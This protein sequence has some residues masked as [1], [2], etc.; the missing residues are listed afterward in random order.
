MLPLLRVKKTCVVVREV[1]DFNY[2]TF[3]AC[4]FVYVWVIRLERNLTVSNF[5]VL[6]FV[7]AGLFK[8]FSNTVNLVDWGNS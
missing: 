1:G 5:N 3:L 7:E 4:K 6:S 8:T 2:A